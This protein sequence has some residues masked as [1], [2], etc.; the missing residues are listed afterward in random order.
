MWNI[1]DLTYWLEQEKRERDRRERNVL[2]IWKDLNVL[3]LKSF[4]FIII[5]I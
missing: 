4:N 2:N 5:V 1:I 3:V